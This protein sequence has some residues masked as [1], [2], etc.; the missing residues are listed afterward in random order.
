MNKKLSL[1]LVAATLA[2]TSMA[3][4]GCGSTDTTPHFSGVSAKIVVWAPAEEEA[5]IKDVVDTYNAKQTEDS[6]KFNYSFV[7]VSEADGGTTLATDPLVTNYPSLVACADDHIN[8]LVNKNIIKSIGGTAAEEIKKNDT[9]FA[10]SCFTNNDSLYA[11]PIT[12]DNGYFLWYDSSYLTSTD[13]GSL[14]TVLSKA[15]AA[16]KTVFMDVPNGWYVNS[17]FMGPDALG[18]DSLTW[19]QTKDADGTAHVSY[20]LDWD[21]EV[22]VSV[23]TYIQS[24]LSPYY[25]DGTLIVDGNGGNGKLESG[26]ADKSMIA[27]V[28]GVWE[29]KTLS[30]S[31]STLAASKLPSFTNGSKTYQ[32]GSFSG[33]KGYVVNSFAST[34]EQKAAY[35][36][37]YLL[38][39]K[40]SQLVRFDKRASIPCNTEAQADDAY[41][42]NVTIGSK[43]LAAQSQYASI[44]SHCAESRY[45]D[46]GKAIGYTLIGSTS[47]TEGD[48][49]TDW[50]TYLKGKCDSLRT[51][52]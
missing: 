48:S 24:V 3:L 46:I 41:K 17:F 38:T 18:T 37:G 44:Q 12:Q 1:V 27:G 25:A 21:N 14:E 39:N 6:A 4:V 9:E 20:T 33:S 7:A 10:V 16:G 23:A 11:F 8:N 29:E 28:S 26:F 34:D 19:S 43:A 40:A 42:N 5:V 52:N 15:K 49:F 35:Y 13:V 51:A 45:W 22:G 50:T 30:A 32:M 47:S 36:L 2:G 31:C